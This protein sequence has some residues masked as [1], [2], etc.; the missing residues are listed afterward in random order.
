MEPQLSADKQAE[1]SEVDNPAAPADPSRD[2][3]Q[4][5]PSG[6]EYNKGSEE[7]KRAAH[8]MIATYVTSLLTLATATITLSATFLQNLYRGQVLWALFVAWGVLAGS[9]VV[10]FLT[11]GQNISLLAESDLRPRRGVLEIVGLIHLLMV[12]IGLAFFAYFAVKNATISASPRPSSSQHSIG[13]SQAL[14]LVWNVGARQQF[15]A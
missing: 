12:I 8:T 2:Q 3:V 9:M 5:S 4:A 10:A 15:D 14:R 7:D 13:S 11:L 1:G 6:D